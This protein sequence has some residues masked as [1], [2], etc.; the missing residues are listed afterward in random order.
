METGNG[1]DKAEAEPVA[2][3]A[4][5]PFQP[6]K[7]LEDVFAFIF[8]DSGSIIGDRNHGTAILSDLHG[9]PT[10]F[11]AIFEGVVHKI[12]HGIEQ[13]VSI[14]CNKHSLIYDSIEMRMLLFRGGIEQLHDL[15][16]DL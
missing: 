13:E 15:A 3:S 9:H 8:G 10:G 12:G 1:S 14:A 7:A 5:T 4:P 11:T 16:C 6:V 2:G